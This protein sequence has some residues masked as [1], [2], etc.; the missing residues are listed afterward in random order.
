MLALALAD[1]WTC[2]KIYNNNKNNIIIIVISYDFNNITIPICLLVPVNQINPVCYIGIIWEGRVSLFCVDLSSLLCWSQA[3]QRTECCRLLH[4][5]QY[6]IVCW[7][8]PSYIQAHHVPLFG[9]PSTPF[10]NTRNTWVRDRHGVRR[11]FF[12]A[13]VTVNCSIFS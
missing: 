6:S 11:L 7:T 10:S 13:I 3:A 2:K 9:M 8:R 4:T 12:F 5:G 1:H